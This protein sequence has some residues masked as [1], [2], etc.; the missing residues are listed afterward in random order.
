MA[1]ISSLQTKRPNYGK[2][3]KWVSLI[4]LV[5]LLVLAVGATVITAIAQLPGAGQL[6]FSFVGGL[7]AALAI[8]IWRIRRHH[9]HGLFGVITP[10]VLILGFFGGVAPIYVRLIRTNFEA[11]AGSVLLALAA[12]FLLYW[13]G[14]EIGW[15]IDR[16]FKERHERLG[17]RLRSEDRKETS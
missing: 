9:Q 8:V 14:I 5:P 10:F 6:L 4:F 7:F 1:F 16:V 3:F 12:G 17:H 15:Q 13:G 11:G 2:L